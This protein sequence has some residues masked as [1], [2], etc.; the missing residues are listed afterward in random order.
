MCLFSENDIGNSDVNESLD[1]SGIQTMDEDDDADQALE[2]YAIFGEE[3]MGLYSTQK[4]YLKR[5]GTSKPDEKY[6]FPK[7]MPQTWK[8]NRN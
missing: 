6:T 7:K 1:D 4:P 2:A 8:R 5:K 3:Q